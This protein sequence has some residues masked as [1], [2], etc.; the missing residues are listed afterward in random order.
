[1]ITCVRNKL[2]CAIINLIHAYFE[3]RTTSKVLTG[4]ERDTGMLP[5]LPQTQISVRP[6]PRLRT[7]K[8]GATSLGAS[9]SPARRCR[10]ARLFFF[11]PSKHMLHAETWFCVTQFSLP[12]YG[13]L[14][15]H[16]A[17]IKLS[18]HPSTWW[19]QL[20]QSSHPDLTQA[21]T[22]GYFFILQIKFNSLV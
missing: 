21:Y 22:H 9:L 14:L 3:G 4:E 6:Q 10:L 5:V 18:A 19:K 13:D 20:A 8:I 2:P 11:P 7:D 12:L 15:S 17:K 1:M 16:P